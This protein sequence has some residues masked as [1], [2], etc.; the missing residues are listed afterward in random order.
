MEDHLKYKKIIII[1]DKFKGSMTAEEAAAAIRDGIMEACEKSG[2]KLPEILLRPLA[3]GGEGS[4]DVMKQLLQKNGTAYKEVAIPTVNH[5]GQQ[6]E[7]SALLFGNTAFIESARVCGLNLIP[8]QNRDLLHSSSYGLGEAIRLLI[9]EYSSRN[10]MLSLGGSGINDAGFGML[11]AL[12]FRFSNNF[13]F[14][15]KDIPT[16]MEGID[17][18]Q[19]DGVDSICPHLKNTKFT[20]ICDVNNPLLGQH[21]ATFVY[22]PQKGGSQ[23]VLDKFESALS[24]WA[25]IVEQWKTTTKDELLFDRNSHGAGAAGGLGFALAT[26]LDAQLISGAEFFSTMPGLNME[27]SSADLVITGEGRFDE[28]SLL[29]K[30]PSH[31]AT[32]CR[33]YHKPLLMVTGRNCLHKSIWQPS[34]FNDVIALNTL[35]KNSTDTFT[36]ASSLLSEAIKAHFQKIVEAV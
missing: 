14:R 27:I 26:V 6:I 2:L 25:N 10:I 32:L 3:D 24:N 5:L 4:M 29:G 17:S 35:F 7:T 19:D 30:L 36:N 12:G 1:N 20:A 13:P 16:F 18:M 8:K 15:N 23:E 22:G 33:K 31:I 11:S 28:S 21:G 34:G 9:E